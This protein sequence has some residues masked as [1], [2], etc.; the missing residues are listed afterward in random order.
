VQIVPD[1]VRLVDPVADDTVIPP[2]PPPSEP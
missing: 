2:P 1:S